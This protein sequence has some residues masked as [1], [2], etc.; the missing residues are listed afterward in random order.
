MPGVSCITLTPW[1]SV[2]SFSVLNWMLCIN[3]L[4]HFSLTYTSWVRAPY[5]KAYAPLQEYKKL[6]PQVCL[7]KS[8]MHIL[9]CC[10]NNIQI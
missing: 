2:S 7:S 3:M 9:P 1:L 4:L 5:Q 6:T 8:S 10:Y